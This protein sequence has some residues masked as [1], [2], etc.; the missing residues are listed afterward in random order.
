MN[1]TIKYEKFVSHSV[2]NENFSILGSDTVSFG[3]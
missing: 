1:L 2:D 3:R